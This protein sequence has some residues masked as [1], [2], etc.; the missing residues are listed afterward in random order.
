MIELWRKRPN[1]SPDSLFLDVQTTSRHTFLSSEL[2]CLPR[3]NPTN[4]CANARIRLL[5]TYFPRKVPYVLHHRPPVFVRMSCDDKPAKF[6]FFF[7]LP[8]FLKNHSTAW[9]H[10][11]ESHFFESK[12]SFVSRKSFNFITNYSHDIIPS[13]YFHHMESITELAFSA[14]FHE[15]SSNHQ[16]LYYFNIRSQENVCSWNNFVFVSSPSCC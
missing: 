11:C 9:G 14:H 3:G 7:W 13:N 6:N 2:Q 12:P 16:L 8:V 10:K 5:A 4:L 1:L 15:T